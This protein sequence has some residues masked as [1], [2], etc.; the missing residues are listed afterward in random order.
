MELGQTQQDNSSPEV[1]ADDCCENQFE[2]L[3]SETERNHNNLNLEA[4]SLIF[5]AAFTQ[6]FILGQ[7]VITANTYPTSITSPPLITQDYTILYQTFLI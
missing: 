7:V 4:P 3:Q 5:V 6:V 2:L 1:N